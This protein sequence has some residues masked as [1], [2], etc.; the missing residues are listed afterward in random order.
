MTRKAAQNPFTR[1]T[2]FILVGVAALSIALGFGLAIFGDD[3]GRPPTAD[4]NTYSRSALGHKAFLRLIGKLDVP[5][6][7]SQYDSA[8]K[9]EDSLLLLLEPNVHEDNREQALEIY[10]SGGS[11]FVVLPKW[12]GRA[13]PVD[14]HRVEEVFLLPD[15]EVLSVLHLV[16]DEATLV[17]PRSK[18]AFRAPEVS[19]TPSLES[20]QLVHS[21]WI[22]P[23]VSA[24]EGILF[25]KLRDAD[26]WILSDPDL[27]ANHGL[28]DGDNAEIA[29]QLLEL[30]RKDSSVVVDETLHGFIRQPSLYRTLFRFP[31]VLVT[32]QVLLTLA[33]LLWSATGRFGKPVPTRPAIAPGKEFL[34]DNMASLLRFG[35]HTAHGLLRYRE[36]AVDAVARRLHAPP[37]LE[38]MALVAWLDRVGQ[39]RQLQTSLDSI[40]AEV[41][42]VTSEKRPEARAIVA[43]ADRIYRWKQEMIHGP[44]VNQ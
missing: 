9:A 10:S 33:L 1:R 3:L 18:P 24:D 41:A 37:T 11:A 39:A 26:V 12:D 25:G 2:L 40:A 20:V 13:D 4:A 44:A 28:D 14:P 21:S 7:V 35:G 22:E 34:I 19:G 16:D 5:V 23:I 32:L 6:L 43:A 31:L 15:S 29:A 42:R 38:G 27:I 30:A 17:R 8:R 36:V